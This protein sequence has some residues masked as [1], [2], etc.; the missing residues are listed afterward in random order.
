VRVLQG[1][2]QILGGGGGSLG[3]KGARHSDAS[4]KPCQ[5]VGNALT[6]GLLDPHFVTSA[7]LGGGSSIETKHGVRGP[8]A[9]FV[10]KLMDE[11]ASA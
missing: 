8:S 9:M 11:D 6:A 2:D 7:L 5:G 4:G 1:M 3:G 10:W